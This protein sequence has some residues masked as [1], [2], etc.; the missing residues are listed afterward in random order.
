MNGVIIS[1]WVMENIILLQ[2]LLIL[3]SID[4]TI[5]VIEDYTRMQLEIHDLTSGFQLLN[6]SVT[7]DEKRTIIATNAA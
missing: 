4:N 5:Y 2:I 6:S 7:L 3:L 1:P